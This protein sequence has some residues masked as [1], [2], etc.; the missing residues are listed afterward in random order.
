MEP[1]EGLR[2]TFQ[3]AIKDSRVTLADGTFDQTGVEDGWA[4]VIVIAQV[5]QSSMSDKETG[6]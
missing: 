1:S 6:D 4:D 3:E 5:Q 2:S